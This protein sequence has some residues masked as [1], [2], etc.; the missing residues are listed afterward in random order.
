MKD[1]K[2]L[3][4]RLKISFSSIVLYEEAFTHRSY[5][6]IYPNLMNNERMEFLGDAVLK[7]IVSEDLFMRYL[8][9]SEGDLSKMRA[10]IVSDRYLSVLATSL[11][12]GEYL[13]L[14]YGEERAGGRTRLSNLANVFEALLGAVF[15]DLGLNSARSF[16][17]GVM[18]EHGGLFTAEFASQDYKSTLQEY[19]QKKKNALPVY[20]TLEERGPDHKKEFVVQGKVTDKGVVFEAVS[21]GSSKKEAEQNVAHQLVEKL[22]LS[23]Q[24]FGVD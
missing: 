21:S 7:L 1:L 9:K 12:L 13:R 11:N 18:K 4:D 23:Q 5:V 3:L 6:K 10:H 16:F 14:S 2:V 20:E 15:L 8:N 19:M 17:L 22:G 24:V